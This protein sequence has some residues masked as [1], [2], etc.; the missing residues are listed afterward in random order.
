MANESLSASMMNAST[1]SAGGE[2]VRVI[3]R[4]RPMS[5]REIGQGHHSAVKVDSSRGVIEVQEKDNPPKAFTFD[6][7][8]DQK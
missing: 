1:T 5:E 6:A 8:Y 3:V 2:A 4:C 7:V